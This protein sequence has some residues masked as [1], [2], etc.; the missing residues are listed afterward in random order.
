MN[1]KKVEKKYRVEGVKVDLKQY[2]FKQLFRD[3]GNK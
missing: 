2:I 3:P 1:I